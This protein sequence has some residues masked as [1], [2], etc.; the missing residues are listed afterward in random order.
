MRRT[1]D[2]PRLIRISENKVKRCSPPHQRAYL[3]MC[4]DRRAVKISELS[5]QTPGVILIGQVRPPDRLCHLALSGKHP[6][7]D[8]LRRI[9]GF[10]QVAGKT[11]LVPKQFLELSNLLSNIFFG[12]NTRYSAKSVCSGS[13]YLRRIRMVYTADSN[14]RDGDLAADLLD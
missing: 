14:E 6:C 10:W 13:N 1:Y 7:H 3:G 5:R 4:Y 8:I 2:H 11:T 12:Y 9:S